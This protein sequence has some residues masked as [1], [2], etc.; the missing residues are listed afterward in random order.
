MGQTEPPPLEVNRAALGILL[1][2]IV[3]FFSIA[4]LDRSNLAPGGGEDSMHSLIMFVIAHVMI[5]PLFTVPLWAPASFL[6][7][8]AYL[9]HRWA[10]VLVPL[11]C[12]AMVWQLLP[13]TL[14]IPPS[15]DQGIHLGS[16]VGI[17]L[18]QAYACVML[19]RQPS[20]DWFRQRAR[21]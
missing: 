12:V 17:L 8:M 5:V 2:V 6:M 9:G 19:A 11:A 15:L 16:V 7:F 18:V 13:E 14:G 1:S 3:F 21:R 10:A 20:R 4:L